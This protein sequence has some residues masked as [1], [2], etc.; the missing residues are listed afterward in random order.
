MSESKCEM[1]KQKY[2]RKS[3]MGYCS[4]EDSDIKTCPYILAI[5]RVNELKA[6]NKN[7]ESILYDE[8]DWK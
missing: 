2:C 5:N 4:A 6:E 7:L 3:S 8:D 1:A